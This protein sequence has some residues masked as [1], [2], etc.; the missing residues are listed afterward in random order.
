MSAST[1]PS[2]LSDPKYGFDLVLAVT[3]DSINGTML[4]YLRTFNN[5]S[6]IQP[7]ELFWVADAT[8]NPV[9]VT[10]NSAFLSS[11]KG[12]DPFSIPAN[13]NVA[14]S[15]LIQN[16][17]GA[18]FLFGVR[19]KL[20]VPN[21]PNPTSLSVVSF[22]KEAIT[23]V[24]LNLYCSTFDIVQFVPGNIFSPSTWLSVSQDP[25][26][27]WVYTTTV[28][29]LFQSKAFTDLPV[30]VQQKIQAITPDM[31]SVQQLLFDLS[32]AGLQSTPNFSTS[33]PTNSPIIAAL[34]SVFC[35]KYFD[36]MNIAGQPALA[37][38]SVIPGASVSPL[39]PSSL[40]LMVNTYVDP[41]TGNPVF[42]SGLTTLNYICNT[43]NRSPPATTGNFAWNWVPDAAAQQDHDRVSSISRSWFA[44]YFNTQ[45]MPYVTKNCFLP[46]PRVSLDLATPKFSLSLASGQN[47]TTSVPPT[48]STIL[49]YSY[50][51]DKSDE[52]GS[53]GALGQM[54]LSTTFNRLATSV[55]GNIVDKTIVDT[56]TITVDHTGVLKVNGA[57]S[58]TDNSQDPKANS[59]LNFWSDADSVKDQV[60]AYVNG[61]TQTS[62]GSI[63]ISAISNFIFPGGKTFTFKDAGFSTNQ[64]LVTYITYTE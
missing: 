21:V 59:F 54:D 15:P 18:R 60:E 45:L 34:Q 62:F 51:A 11:S 28:D 40:D 26:A 27:P 46:Q 13:V 8:G 5:N 25:A 43:G 6:Q 37:Y 63:P 42:G 16:L 1:V 29:L 57:S 49:S 17:I 2:N 39:Q 14:T 50:S 53:G 31:F 38:A 36:E 22:D 44:N 61:V 24:T 7:V 48:G 12:T 20:G 41:S 35:S 9:L 4:D 19:F 56:W 55:S 64:D 52:A 30:D 10:D 47:P 32:T 33:L 23:G 3:Q 58:T